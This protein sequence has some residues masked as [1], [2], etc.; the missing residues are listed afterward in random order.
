M[1]RK[2]KAAIVGIVFVL[3]SVFLVPVAQ[4]SFASP[5]TQVCTTGNQIISLC[6]SILVKGYGSVSYWLFGMGGLYT[7]LPYSRYSVVL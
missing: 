4:V 7:V 2:T 3:A 6:S 1:G 5:N